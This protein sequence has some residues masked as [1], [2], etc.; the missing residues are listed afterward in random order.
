ME[1]DEFKS[2]WNAIQDKEFQQQKIS[3]E[4][5]EQI[6]MNI[7]ETLG[8]MHAKSIYWKNIGKRVI[9]MLIGIL[10]MVLLITLVKAFYTHSKVSTALVSTIYIAVLVIYCMATMWVYNRQVQIFT[11]YNNGNVKESVKQ[12][13]TAFKRFYL[14]SNIIY[15][16]LYPAYYYAVIK[17]LMPYWHPSL[18]TIFTIVIIVT[19]LS[20]A[21]GHWYYKVKFFKKLRSLEANLADLE[22]N[23]PGS[24][25][26]I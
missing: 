9:P 14:I 26:N 25:S 13:I 17:L 20:L 11:I 15:L 23:N 21:G 12:T 2:H 7:T 1:L 3:Q 8:Q 16:F 22:E 18:Q 19:V 10:A 5:L 6:I 24:L 4:K